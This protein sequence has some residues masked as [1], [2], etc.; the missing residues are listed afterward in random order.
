MN[1]M[2]ELNKLL[3]WPICRA[4]AQHIV[5]DKPADLM[6]RLLVSLDFL[7][8]HGYWPDFKNPRTFSE[9]VCNRMLFDRDT[10]WTM[11]S[12]K[13]LVREYVANK[14]GKKY[15]VPVIWQG[16]RPEEIPFD[17]F[18]LKFVIKTNHG[19]G[20][21][22]IVKDR[23]QLN[24]N[25]ARK[26]LK[27][28][29]S[30][31]FC[32]D[33]VSGTAWAYKN[34]RPTII[35]ESFLDDNGN[36]PLDYKFFCFSGRVEYLQVSID[37]FGDASERILD[38]DFNP[39]NLYNGVRLY[40]GKIVCPDNYQEMVQVAETIAQGFNFIRVDLYSVNKRIYFGE[41]TCY[42]AGGMA[43]FIPRKYDFIFGEKWR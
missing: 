12:D 43:R 13:W 4:Y 32:L 22:I 20:Y 26:Q 38:R 33:R 18:P 11:L 19:C 3:Y 34:I 39:L 40:K 23:T 25:K 10:R 27:K 14:V 35:V 2:S 6:M 9:K 31:N 29:L 30:E 16:D 7:R 15:L 28:W 41:L 21:N 17:Q 24:Q 1:L 37:R 5:R 8:V 36:V 42:P